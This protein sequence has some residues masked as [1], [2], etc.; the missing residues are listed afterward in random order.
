ML[1]ITFEAVNPEAGRTHLFKFNRNVELTQNLRPLQWK[2]LSQC[3]SAQSR[4]P[5]TAPLDHQPQAGSLD[6]ANR[7]AVRAQTAVGGAV[8]G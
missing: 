6:G 7:A 4:I 5:G 8:A 1:R 3:D 2:T